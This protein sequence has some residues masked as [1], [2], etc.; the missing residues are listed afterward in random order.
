MGTSSC[1]PELKRNDKAARKQEENPQKYL[2]EYK[3]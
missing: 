1:R 2:E 3:F